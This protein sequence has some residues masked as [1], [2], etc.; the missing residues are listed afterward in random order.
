MAAPKRRAVTDA[1]KQFRREEILSGARTY[2]ETVG[3]ESFS[4]AQLAARLDIVKGTLYLYFPTKEA[5]ILAL[6]GRALEAW[7]EVMKARLAKP[8]TDQQFLKAF[9]DTA[10]ND[11]VLVPLLIRLQHVIEHNVSIPL[12]IDSKRHFQSCLGAIAE[13]AVSALNLVESQANELI[14]SLGVLLSGAAQ[15]DQG[16]SLSEEDLPEDVVTLM[17][18]LSSERLFLTNGKYILEGIRRDN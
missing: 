15:S 7:S 8:I 3:Y 18:R 5:I 16:P 1:Q 2:F 13:R 10:M 11:P 9:H 17:T 6:F 12:L 14:W 4:M